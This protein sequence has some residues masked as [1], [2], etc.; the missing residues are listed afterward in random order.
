MAALYS[1]MDLYCG[2]LLCNVFYYGYHRILLWTLWC[3]MYIISCDINLRTCVRKYIPW[4]IW[5]R[6]WTHILFLSEE[7]AATRKGYLF[8]MLFV[9]LM[10]AHSARDDSFF[11][12]VLSVAA[13]GSYFLIFL[14]F[15]FSF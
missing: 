5:T 2:H 1:I 4:D 7:V 12:Y 14:L 10:D 15:S 11:I 3:I 8:K 6:P 13:C 9:S